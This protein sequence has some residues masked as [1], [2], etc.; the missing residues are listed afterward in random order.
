MIDFMM[1]K[2]G[3]TGVL[4][5]NGVLNMENAH[6]FREALLEALWRVNHVFLNLAELTEIDMYCLQLLCSACKNTLN[7]KKRLT[8]EREGLEIFNRAVAE[9]AFIRDKDCVMKCNINCL[10]LDT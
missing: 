2:A 4:T 7:S 6:E 8:L 10:L 1:K 5:I 9:A 3:D